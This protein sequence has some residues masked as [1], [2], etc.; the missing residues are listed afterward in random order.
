MIVMYVFA[1]LVLLRVILVALGAALII[2]PV[3]DC[4]ACF[5]ETM[6]IQRRWLSRSMPWLEWRW[7]P[8]CGW[9]GPA[10]RTDAPAA[11]S[12]PDGA[13]GASPLRGAGH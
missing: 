11:R 12:A 1:A 6:P 5:Q 8:G 3:Q 13:P 9:E 7:C 4:P 10:R 2:R